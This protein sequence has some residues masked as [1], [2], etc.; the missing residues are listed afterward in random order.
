M[1]L[2][3]LKKM[4][5]LPEWAH[6]SYSSFSDLSFSCFEI[7]K[8]QGKNAKEFAEQAADNLHSKYIK[9]ASALNGY[10]N[11]DLDFSEL[12][13]DHGLLSRVE[14]AG[15]DNRF[16]NKVIRLEHTS[17]NPNKGLHIGH[18]RNSYIGEF[19]RKSLI[20]SRARVTTS[21]FI[22]D[23]G[24]Q[25]ADII[26]GFKYLG[27][28]IETEEKFDLY[29][30]KIY[31]EINEDYAKDNSLL[32][33]RKQVLL[34]IENNDEQTM[35]LLRKIVDK[36]LISQLST[37]TGER[38]KYD[39]LDLE[40][41]IL[42]EGIVKAAMDKLTREG[43][44]AISESEKNNGC[45]VSVI[46]GSE[47]TLSR[48]DGTSLYIAKDIAYAMI[49]HNI[50]SERIKYKKFSQNFDGSD[51]LI[52]NPEGRDYNLP[53]IDISFTLT[54]SAQNAEQYAVKSIIERFSGKDSYNHYGYEPVAI[55]KETAAY[56]GI[57]T[58]D[59]FMRMSGR[60]GITV[61]FDSL[62]QVIKNRIIEESAKNGKKMG[63]NDAL[64][65]ASS[66]VRYYILKFS[67][68]KM[69]VFDINDAT[70]L[71]GDS[72]VYINYSYS[73]AKSVLD[74]A[75]NSDYTNIEFDDAENSIIRELLFWEEI[76]DDAVVNLKSSVICD[77]L[78]KIADTF[79]SF[80]EKNRI[81]GDQKENSR[82]LI[83]KAFKD[84]TEKLSDFV[85]MELL[86]KI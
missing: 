60:K 2:H 74:K 11:I 21:N 47:V 75:A 43:V 67:P 82:L 24:A 72:A 55:S 15:M 69:V 29:C 38:I 3:D 44:A 48:S 20:Y 49:K 57:K 14:I 76:L 63:D 36:V 26:V 17:V 68:S 86:E 32:E 18:M 78:H 56:L 12:E 54:D 23:T 59:K 79:N 28:E 46:D 80:Y 5:D 41:Y 53:E 61:E 30:S 84:I 27:K 45:L 33:K 52:S 6:V 8:K 31:K 66:V 83:T 37:L 71:K 73:R 35:E 65:L 25:V 77:Y 42:G 34:D 1:K 62:L 70:S 9:K 81:I 58:E 7:A 16:S 39:L 4:L 22:E 10:V 40:R 85:G 51:I 50:L 19:I 13:K 64:K